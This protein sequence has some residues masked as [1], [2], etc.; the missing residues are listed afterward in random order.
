MTQSS[1]CYEDSP[2]NLIDLKAFLKMY[3]LRYHVDLKISKN[4]ISFPLKH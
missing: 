2:S 3:P 1:R 4:P